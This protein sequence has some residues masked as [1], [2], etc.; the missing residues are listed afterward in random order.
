MK[1]KKSVP[2]AE[3]QKQKEKAELE[4]ALK[5]VPAPLKPLFADIV[6]LPQRVEKLEMAMNRLIQI[7]TTASE[8]GGPPAQGGG[9]PPGWLIQLAPLI[10]RFLGG[11]GGGPFERMAVEM[12]MRNMAF[13]SV[14]QEQ[15]VKTMG[16]EF[17]KA[18][19]D[20]VKELTKAM[21]EKKTEETPE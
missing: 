3:K 15:M 4:K 20:R 12:A 16:R 7:M 1:E 13:G 21:R 18:Y 14:M 9:G 17:G 11:G 8:G 19:S 5:M 2:D 10:G 6:G